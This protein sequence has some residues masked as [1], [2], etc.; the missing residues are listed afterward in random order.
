MTGLGRRT[1]LS[2]V[3]TTAAMAAAGCTELLD[4]GSD[5]GNDGSTDDGGEPTD[6]NGNETDDSDEIDGESEESNE[7]DGES[8]EESGLETPTEIATAFVE[9]LGAQRYEAAA[10][11]SGNFVAGNLEQFWMGYTAVHGEFEEVLE[12]DE[13]DDVQGFEQQLGTDDVF[14][15]TVAFENGTDSVRTAVNDGEVVYAQYNGE[16]ARPEY[17]D[18]GSFTEQRVTVEAEGCHLN[19]V[20][21]LPTG[22]TAGTE[23]DEVPGVVLVHGSGAADMD[24]T[25]F[26]TQLFTDLAEGLASRGIATLRYDKRTAVCAVAPENH[27]LDHVTVDDALVAIETL[28]SVEGVDADETIVVGHS[29]GGMAVPRVLER[30]GDLAGGVAMAAPGRSMYELLIEQYEHFA[31][32]GDHEWPSV[33][34]QYDRMRTEVDRVRNGN[35]ERGERVLGYPGALWKSLEAYDH[36]GRARAIDDPLL[37]VQGSRDFQVSPEDD[38]AVWKRELGDRPTTTFESYD[39]LNHR[40]MPGTGPSI[41]GEYMARNNVEAA[42]IDDLA[43]WIDGRTDAEARTVASVGTPTRIGSGTG[44][45]ASVASVAALET[46]SRVGTDTGIGVS[47]RVGTYAGV[48]AVAPTTED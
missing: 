7:N 44:V 31:T 15:F 42:V 20:V 46:G 26:G 29:M 4:E 3:S 35:Y 1:L 10:D 13:P 27:T 11:L 39:G 8:D 19:G 36:V 38:F 48:G 32:V 14:D 24:V 16:Y 5:D 12:T 43:A 6:G 40:F 22:A 9:K 17:V 18:R 37:F 41:S 28:R 21:T 25:S 23:T 34:E 30:D 33:T 47:D 2:A 45:S